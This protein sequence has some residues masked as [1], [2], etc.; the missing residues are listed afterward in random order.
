MLIKV[1]VQYYTDI[2]NL[3]IKFLLSSQMQAPE[4]KNLNQT[5]KIS[6]D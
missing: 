2:Y 6:K 3:G 5:H 1:F 4:E